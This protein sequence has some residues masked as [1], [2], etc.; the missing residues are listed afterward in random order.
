MSHASVTTW[1][2]NFT[3][4]PIAGMPGRSRIE[5]SLAAGMQST[6]V[7]PLA[8]QG[9]GLEAYGESIPKDEV[10]GDLVD[11]VMRGDEVIAYVA[12]VSGHGLRA[13]VLMAMIKTA[14][15]YGL[16]LG[17]PMTK[18][19]GDLNRVLPS[20]KQANMFVTVAMLRFDGSG[21]AEYIS[22]GHVPLLEYRRRQG[23]VVRHSLPQLPLG[24]FAETEYTSQRIPYEVG[25]IFVLVSD[26]VV[27]VGE[28][29]DG[30]F[31]FARLEQLLAEY[32]SVCLP[33][34]VQS[35]YAEVQT[36]GI[37]QDDQTVLLVRATEQAV[38]ETDGMQSSKAKKTADNTESLETE[39][40]RL[41][42]QLASDLMQD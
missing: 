38:P 4:L 23:D 12:D 16:L 20:L 18:L 14:V 32:R 33:D 7:P 26:G 35:I 28:Q 41:L 21:E 30:E 5:P 15:R 36:H 34:L 39:W 29:R 40:E 8:Y 19:L 42:D 27:E 3:P 6:L 9:F 2:P 24:L 10:G 22:A 17:Q 25:D 37:R 31:G 13:G 11:L 1:I